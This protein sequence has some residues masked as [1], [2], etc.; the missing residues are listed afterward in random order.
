MENLKE[1]HADVS[2]LKNKQTLHT[3]SHCP[4]S[5]HTAGYEIERSNRTAGERNDSN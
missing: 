4:S 1:R 2:V 5:K 3:I